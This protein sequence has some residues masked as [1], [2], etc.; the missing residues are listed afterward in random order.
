MSQ[1]YFRVQVFFKLRNSIT[2]LPIGMQQKA[3]SLQFI[4]EFHANY[5]KTLKSTIKTRPESLVYASFIPGNQANNMHVVGV[6]FMK[7][8]TKNNATEMK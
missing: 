8:G 6:A 1:K 4:G 7:N 2:T 3:V 5:F